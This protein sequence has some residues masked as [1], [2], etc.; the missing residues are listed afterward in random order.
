M[1]QFYRANPQQFYQPEKVH[2]AHIIKNIEA[3]ADEPDARSALISAQLELTSGKPFAKVADRYSDC[4]GGG[5]L[6][7]IAR[8]EMVEEFDEVVF[9]LKKGEC[10]DIF[11]TVFGLHIAT[12][13]GRKAA[14]VSPF[15][16]IRLSLSRSLF[17]QKKQAV[18]QRV[19]HDAMQRSRITV[20]P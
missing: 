15:E 17:E 18:I 12:V 11:R 4:G 1:E 14:G 10:S 16:E 20:A 2:A 6:G 7:W 13:L 19:L 9:S 5:L 8:G 3:P